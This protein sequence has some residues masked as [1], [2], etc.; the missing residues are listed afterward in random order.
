MSSTPLAPKRKKGVRQYLRG[1]FSRSPSRS[2]THST[3]STQPSPQVQ[4]VE[5]TANPNE[6]EAPSHAFAAPNVLPP[7]SAQPLGSHL[8]SAPATFGAK[9]Q[10]KT[11]PGNTPPGSESAD[12]ATAGR[13]EVWAGLRSSLQVL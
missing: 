5:P 9:P 12:A 13:N 7:T 11:H 4:D 6:N 1:L 8:A 3:T 10:A 2:S